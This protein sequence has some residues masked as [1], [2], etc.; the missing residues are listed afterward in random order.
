MVRVMTSGVFDILHPGHLFY[1]EEARALGDELYV[2]VATDN[3]ARNRKHEPINTED[4]RLRMVQAL[5][6][7]DESFLGYDGDI[8]KIVLEIKPDIIAIGHDQKHTPDVIKKDLA[9]RG[10]NVEVV[11]LGRVDHDLNGTRKI[12]RKVIDWHIFQKKMEEVEKGGKRGD[13]I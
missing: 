8:Y 9:D 12:I 3:T 2:V 10:L 5:K 6:P 11:R 1:L 13:D 7:V 4:M